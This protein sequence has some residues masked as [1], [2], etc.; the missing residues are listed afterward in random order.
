MLAGYTSP[1][2]WPTSDGSAV[3]AGSVK[4]ASNAIASSLAMPRIDSANPLS[5][6]TLTSST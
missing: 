6:V 4:P 1:E 5:G 3:S 2:T